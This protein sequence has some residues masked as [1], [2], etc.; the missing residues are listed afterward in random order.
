MPHRK[1]NIR[2]YMLYQRKIVFK[3]Q[4]R[5]TTAGTFTRVFALEKERERERKE[6]LSTGSG[7]VCLPTRAIGTP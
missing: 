7:A 2:E 6:A 3:N 4:R 5:V 1:L